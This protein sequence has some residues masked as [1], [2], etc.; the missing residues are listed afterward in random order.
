MRLTLTT[1]AS[2]PVGSAHVLNGQLL[3]CLSLSIF[4]LCLLPPILS[5]RDTPFP[6]FSLAVRNDLMIS[7]DVQVSEENDVYAGFDFNS[8]KCCLSSLMSTLMGKM[9]SH[10]CW[11]FRCWWQKISLP[12]RVCNG[13]SWIALAANA[14]EIYT[15][16]T[17]SRQQMWLLVADEEV[18]N[19]SQEMLWSQRPP[20]HQEQMG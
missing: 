2:A 12:W 7:T 6:H 4:L 19:V 20:C 17:V 14:E 1:G 8:L 18:K 3:V 5:K 16:H 15:W 10:F 13:S 11:G 9:G